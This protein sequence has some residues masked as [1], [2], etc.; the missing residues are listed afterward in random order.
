MKMKKIRI[1]TRGSRLALW[2]A[3]HVCA[4]LATIDIDTEI[5][6][7]KTKGDRIQHLSFDKIDGKGFF[8]KEIEESLLAEETD[9][10]V[11]SLKDLPTASTEGLSLSALSERYDPADIL[12]M[13]KQCFD[14][15]KSFRLKEGASLG[16][17]SARRKLQ[18]R[19]ERADL[20]IVDIRGNVPTRLDKVRHGQVDSIV[21]AAA[22]VG[23]LGLSLDDFEAVRLNPKEFI[24]AP[25]QGVL[26]LQTRSEDLELRK[27]LMKLHHPATA[28]CTN[29]ERGLLKSLGGGCH[30][31]LGAYC[32]KDEQGNYQMYA[33]YAENWK[34]QAIYAHISQT[35]SLGLT[36]AMME[37]LGIGKE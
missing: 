31:P 32:Y 2:Q 9:L 12:V 36:E 21:L 3:N 27:A 25:A 5:R 15:S 6:I 18:I 17:S 34:S 20:N 10:A 8:T 29:I 37:R 23:R 26:G 4:Q 24:P 19:S 28:Q 7:I 11:H 16:T 14:K 1:A 22:G 35:T 33:A 13:N 30:T